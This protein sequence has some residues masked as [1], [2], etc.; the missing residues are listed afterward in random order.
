MDELA[1]VDAELEA[2]EVQ[3]ERARQKKAAIA[4]QKAAAA[5]STAASVPNDPNE[6]QRQIDD[7][8]R[9]LELE[10][11]STDGNAFGSCSSSS[12]DS[13]DVP[14]S[15]PRRRST[16]K[17]KH[18]TPES[19][20]VKPAR[21]ASQHEQQSESSSYTPPSQEP[22]RGPSE[23]AKQ[24]HAWEKPDWALPSDVLSN[25]PAIQ[26][27]SIQNGLKQAKPGYERKVHEADLELI[28]GK[29]V[30]HTEKKPDPRL[31]WIVVNM[32]GCKVGKIVMHLFGNFLPIVD[33]FV[34][35]K[36]LELKRNGNDGF[37]VDD[38]E[39]EFYVHAGKPGTFSGPAS[40]CFGVI[41][42][43]FDIFQKLKVA[44][45]DAVFTIKQSHIYPVKKAK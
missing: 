9:Q 26:S 39:P 44:A 14:C 2:L 13:N 32:D 45:P 24:R 21:R 3:L 33:I 4:R 30:Q 28:N 43:G 23:V 8:K 12:L 25:T 18:A 34:E 6:L 40:A 31:V 1:A 20:P 15:R 35:L 36:G 42:E 7:L 29:F 38:I 11:G 10:Q 16:I 5:A 22:V 37:V 19:N 17:A 41:H 27:E